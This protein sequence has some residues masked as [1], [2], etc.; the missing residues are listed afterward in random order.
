MKLIDQMITDRVT[1]LLSEVER[2][3]KE[4]VDNSD[5]KRSSTKVAEFTQADKIPPDMLH[6]IT[7][8]H[9][10]IIFLKGMI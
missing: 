10:Q 9:L 8:I 2:I 3:S 1:F 4:I 6:K 5:V 7:V